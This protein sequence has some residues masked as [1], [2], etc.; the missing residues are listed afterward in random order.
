MPGHGSVDSVMSQPGR[1]DGG[2]MSAG[3]KVFDGRPGAVETGW[4][5]LVERS[6]YGAQTALIFE[7]CHEI[8]LSNR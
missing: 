6:G 4:A 3:V 5:R 7:V 2:A 1:W 8:D